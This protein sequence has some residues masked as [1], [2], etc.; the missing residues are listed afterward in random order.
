MSTQFDTL[1]T[2]RRLEA[3]GIATKQAEAIV[4][5]IQ[6]SRDTAATKEDLDSNVAALS[7]DLA[8]NTAMLRSELEANTAALRSELEA[9][10][11]ALRSDLAAMAADLRA[12]I[13]GV[14]AESRAEMGK[15]RGELFRALWIQGAG[16]VGI[17]LAS[18]IF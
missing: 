14:A 18:K 8:A 17:L 13:Q 1:A 15:L 3:A 7:S 4:F 2:A 11:K 12:E 6:E 9:N 16:V 5:A 10:T